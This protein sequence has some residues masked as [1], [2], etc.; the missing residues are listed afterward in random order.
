M[1]LQD[2]K[3]LRLSFMLIGPKLWAEEG[4][5]DT[6]TE[7]PSFTIWKIENL[8]EMYKNDTYVIKFYLH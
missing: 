6:H 3:Q 8:L 2:S 1:S 4:H 7:C 5:T